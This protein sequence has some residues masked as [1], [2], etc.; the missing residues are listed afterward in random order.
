MQFTVDSRNF[1]KALELVKKAMP[2]KS[3]LPILENAHIIAHE[4]DSVVIEGTNLEVAIRIKL[5]SK[6]VAVD[7]PGETWLRAK[8]LLQ[9]VKG[10]GHT[11]LQ[12]DKG[13]VYLAKANNTITMTPFKDTDEWPPIP[14][15]EATESITL[16]DAMTRCAGFQSTEDTRH[17]LNG[18]C[19]D[20]DGATTA[21]V[22]TSGRILKAV[23]LTHTIAE[24]QYIIPTAAVKIL[25]LKA[26]P[27]QPIW[28]MGHA[29]NQVVFTT[30]NGD[31][32]MVTRQIDG[33]FP[34]YKAVVKPVKDKASICIGVSKSELMD[35]VKEV[36][37]LYT[38][39]KQTPKVSI[40]TRDGELSISAEN[41][42][43]ELKAETKINAVIE[44]TIKMYV[45]TN[46][47]YTCMNSIVSDDLTL[48]MEE[49]TEDGVLVAPISI[50][51]EADEDTVIMPMRR[52][53]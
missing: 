50:E 18:V 6:D 29:D 5:N 39:K 36:A 31:I 45:N 1:K 13:K 32:E 49:A 22:A 21:V 25:C 23:R 3:T 47:F 27:D 24:G 33:E 28:G 2:T 34:D 14:E 48:K 37:S 41:K 51:S 17:F 8:P 26:F 52:D 46:L 38:S 42:E 30:D 44:G 7:K 53:A 19:I 15:I 10:G 20:S 4:D 35:A 16:K 40:E 9:V 43:A 11:M 12:Q